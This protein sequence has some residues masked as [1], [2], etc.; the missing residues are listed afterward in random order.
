MKSC[1]NKILVFLL[2]SL[3]A[4]STFAA[5]EAI[6]ITATLPAWAVITPSTTSANLTL[7]GTPGASEYNASL[8]TVNLS[9]NS[10]LGYSLEMRSANDGKLIG[11]E[12]SS[13]VIPYKISYDAQPAI[14]LTHV[15]Q[16]IGGVGNSTSGIAT[17]PFTKNLDIMIS[18]HAA[19]AVSAQDYTDTVIFTM[20]AH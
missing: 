13:Q 16:N 10:A 4:H 3:A 1:S 19:N 20:T 6:T 11:V 17:T 15:P 14:A 8:L 18:N 5:D 9:H 7:D 12:N 2:L